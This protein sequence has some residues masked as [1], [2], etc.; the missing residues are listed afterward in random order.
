[1]EDLALAALFLKGLELKQSRCVMR[2]KE[3]ISLAI[4]PQGER[5][6]H[7][8]ASPYTWVQLIPQIANA[9]KPSHHVRERS[10]DLF[11]G[12]AQNGY[13]GDYIF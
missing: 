7:L 6:L 8:P 5:T 9:L 10:I 2:K 12:N 4:S 13:N 1:M 3:Q 11:C